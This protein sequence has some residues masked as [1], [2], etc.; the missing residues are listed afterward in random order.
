MDAEDA[1]VEP[2]RTR[3][4]HAAAH[5]MYIKLCRSQ[6][7]HGKPSKIIICGSSGRETWSATDGTSQSDPRRAGDIALLVA[8]TWGHPKNLTAV[9][10]GRRVATERRHRAFARRRDEASASPL[11][12]PPPQARASA[13]VDPRD[14]LIRSCPHRRRSPCTLSP[15]RPTSDQAKVVSSRGACK[16]VARRRRVDKHLAGPPSPPLHG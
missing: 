8:D 1:D 16:G 9:R 4:T 3:R 13:S 15:S 2:L 12:R 14:V 5:C 11:L 7:G 10:R 6:F